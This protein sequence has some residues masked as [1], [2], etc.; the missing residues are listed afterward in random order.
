MKKITAAVLITSM[1]AGIASPLGSGFRAE[2]E[3]NYKAAVSNIGGTVVQEAEEPSGEDS[4][5]QAIS[6]LYDQSQSVTD[7]EILASAE[8]MPSDFNAVTDK[9]GDEAQDVID[10]LKYY[11]VVKSGYMSGENTAEDLFAPTIMDEW[12][13]Q[14]EYTSFV[15]PAT[16]S[17]RALIP[18]IKV[19][20][21]NVSDKSAVMDIYEWMTV[22]Y[23]AEDSDVINATAY[24]YNFSVTMLK[25]RE[26]WRIATV[27]NTDQ[28]FDWM[29]EEAEE[30]AR[31]ASAFGTGAQASI[32]ADDATQMLAA[33]KVPYTYNRTSAISYADKYC[34]NYNSKYNSY[35]GRGGDCANFVSQCLY[36]GGFPQDSEWYKHSV[37]WI[38]VMKQIAHFKSYGTFLNANNGNL[39]KGNPIYFDWNGDGVY[40]HATICAGRNSNGVAILD[41]HTRD[42]YHATWTNWS[43]K[44]AGTIQ[45]RNSGTATATSVSG[46]WKT[47][48]V[49][50]YYVNADGS[51]IKSSFQSIGG[52][53]YYFNSKGYIVKGWV[54]VNSKKY[55]MNRSTGVMCTG[56]VTD[57]GHKYY[58]GSNG[59]AYTEWNQISGSWYYFKPS[60]C[61]MATGFYLV[62]GK[63]HYFN[64]KGVE[65][66][67]WITVSGKKY[68]LD[69][70]GV[71]QTGWQTINKK[72]YYFNSNG[73]MVTGNV[74]IDNVVYRFDSNGVYQ[75][76]APAGSVV[77]S[78]TSTKKSTTTV[79][80]KNGWVKENGKTYYYKNGV[81]KTGWFKYSEQKTY[82]FNANGSMVANTWKTINGSR[83]YFDAN[84]VMKKNCW[85]QYK[86]NWYYLTARGKMKT[87]WL[88]LQGRYFYLNKDGKMR[89]GWFKDTDGETYYLDSEG[90]MATGRKVING[91]TYY[92]NSSGALKK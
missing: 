23:G 3:A 44:K 75:G 68:H 83:Y 38:N 62:K 70:Y 48:S 41:S 73:V 87:G 35:K 27:D 92:F 43:F 72:K 16:D 67:G 80:K 30:A 89:T 17:I 2:M 86:N 64:S 69:Q 58:L 66:F 55:F 82:Y 77:N 31:E 37:A 60:N 28:N 15:M 18:R 84:G 91:K 79:A 9:M 57:S 6:D 74:K 54:T 34:I 42:L 21:V 45:L 71:V 22:G 5:D 12:H 59:V 8:K 40:D 39:L 65:Q 51:K 53:T 14:S 61:Q 56:W 7:K 90:L 36:A 13:K 47:D 46:Q 63:K 88:N 25:T 24:G 20:K 85:F 1:V 76:K 33:T 52:K 26:G 10:R 49:G 19:T 78:S 4:F 29:Q 50:K 11:E 81:K 32:S